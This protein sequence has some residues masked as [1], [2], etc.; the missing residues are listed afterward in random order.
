[1][2]KA[3]LQKNVQLRI[4]L[5]Q[6]KKNTGKISLIIMLIVVLAA[7]SKW[8]DYKKYTEAG[9]K[10]YS[11]KMDS[12]KTYP[13]NQRIKITGLLPADPKIV[14]VKVTWNDGKDSVIY[15]V[16]KGPGVD[17]FSKIVPVP[18]GIY[19]F[20][21]QTFDA[22]GNSSMKVN[23]AGTAY[24]PK[25]QSGLSN[26]VINRAELMPS[27]KT[28]LAWDNLDAASGALGTW[29]RYTKVGDVIDSVFVPL[30]QTLTSLNNFKSGTS[31][32]IRTLYL[33]KPNSIDTFY[34]P[35]Q[36]V[37]VKYEITSQYLSNT[38]PGFQRATFD[39]RWG[40]LAAPWITNDAAKNKNGINGGYS[41]DAGGVINWET[42]NNTPVT[43]GIVYQPTSS[44]LP[45]GKYI[46]SFDE[47]S[48]LQANST[49]YCIAAAGG[50]GIP[51]LA[52]LT[53]ALGYVGAYNGTNIGSTSPSATDTR[54]F[55]FTLTAPSV[56]S[57]G[58]LANIVGSGNP[59]SYIQ[60]K[61]IQ[62]FSSN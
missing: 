11:G 42:W 47:Y 38:G 43:N 9:E 25:Y 37:G 41:S 52:N 53:T 56:V 6:M 58:F 28:E 2:I 8:D 61:R 39:G 57:I 13:G 36:T 49:I 31:V 26:R 51:I 54:S 7:C 4:K 18:E 34:S 33:P 27:G 14:K 62:L 5:K 21:I 10:I 19:N 20:T 50:T 59:G 12:V 23:V 3:T 46:V 22:V 48:E 35:Q 45:A 24:G 29:V 32:L 30:S 40:T 16:T 55:S 15:A 44:P 60:I 1:M 17:T